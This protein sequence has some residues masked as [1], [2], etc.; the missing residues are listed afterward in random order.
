MIEEIRIRGLGV[1][2]DAVLELSP[3]AGVTGIVKW[4]PTGA[5]RRRVRL[6]TVREGTVVPVESEGFPNGRRPP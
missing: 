1:I 2:E 6:G 4:D 5:S 3:W